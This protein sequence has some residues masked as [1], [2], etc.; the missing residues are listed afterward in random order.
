MATQRGSKQPQKSARRGGIILGF[1][2]VI[3]LAHPLYLWPQL[4][5]DPSAF[6]LAGIIRPILT[7]LGGSLL[8]YA[9]LVAYRDAW[10]PV[11]PR[12]AVLFPVTVAIAV[13]GLQWY[14]E[15]VLGL[16]GFRSMDNNPVLLGAFSLIFMTGGSL[17]RRERM[18]AV[19]AFLLGCLALF[20]LGVG[21]DQTRLTI[22]LASGVAL[23]I[24]GVIIGGVGY[25]LTAPSSGDAPQSPRGR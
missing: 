23:G 22:A 24:A 9:G 21:L 7:M 20:L 2:A 10:R 1:L 15:A 12:T 6:L 8:A 14:D 19:V 16:A 13:L 11:T 17:I 3:L 4:G 25:L 18:K 5:S